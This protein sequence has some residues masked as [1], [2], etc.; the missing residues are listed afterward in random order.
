MLLPI[1]AV[2]GAWSHVLTTCSTEQWLRLADVETIESSVAADPGPGFDLTRAVI[3]VDPGHGGRDKGAKG[4]TGTNESDFNLAI[5]T[6]LEERLSTPHDVDWAEGRIMPGDSYP[7]VGRVLLTRG[8]DG[9]DQGD[10]ELG[11]AY[12]AEIANQAGAD[13]LVSIHNNTTPRII[14]ETPGSDVFYAV[15]SPGSDRLASLIHQE[16]LR[17]LAPFGSEWGSAAV[18][19]PKARVDAETGDDFYGLLRRSVP[20]AVIV[21]GMYVTNPVEETLLQSRLVQQAYADAVYRGLVRFLT[22]DET[23]SELLEPVLFEGN[24]GSPSTT[25][26]VVPTQ[27]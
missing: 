23:G 20:P 7:A 14:K 2:D 9:P 10:V 25:S 11:L 1:L 4:A 6:L 18:S 3:V 15:S 5:A 13:A 8:P 24:V 19:G 26:C 27:P 22:T 16:L 17:G 21:E 12:R